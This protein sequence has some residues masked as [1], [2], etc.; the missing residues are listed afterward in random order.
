M[1][2]PVGMGWVWGLKCHPHGS[3]G[4]RV[5]KGKRSKRERACRG[6][7][8]REGGSVNDGGIVHT[9]LSTF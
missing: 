2:I 6:V 4:K 3:P 8:G 7:Q 9:F 1:G 5:E